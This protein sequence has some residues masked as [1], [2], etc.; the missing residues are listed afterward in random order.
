MSRSQVKV[1][2]IFGW[3]EVTWQRYRLFCHE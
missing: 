1:D 2:I 3:L